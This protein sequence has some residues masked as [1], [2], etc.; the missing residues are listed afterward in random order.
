MLPPPNMCAVCIRGAAAWRKVRRVIALLIMDGCGVR[1]SFVSPIIA[2]CYILLMA[3]R[4]C[5][6]SRRSGPWLESHPTCCMATRPQSATWAL[7]LRRLKAI[8]TPATCWVNPLEILPPEYDISV[9]GRLNAHDL[10]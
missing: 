5:I 6:L 4:P 7:E 2:A 1:L 9:I 10:L 3:F 8:R